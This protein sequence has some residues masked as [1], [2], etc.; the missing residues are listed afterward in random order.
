MYFFDIFFPF[1]GAFRGL[2]SVHLQGKKCEVPLFS[3][4]PFFP[5]IFFAFFSGDFNILNT[6]FLS[7]SFG[8]SLTFTCI[9]RIQRLLHFLLYSLLSF[10]FFLQCSL[11]IFW[12]AF[13]WFHCCCLWKNSLFLFI[14]SS[15]FISSLSSFSLFRGLCTTLLNK[16]HIVIT[17]TKHLTFHTIPMI[18]GYNKLQFKHCIIIC[19]KQNSIMFHRFQENYLDTTLPLKND[20][21]RLL[22]VTQK[23]WSSCYSHITAIV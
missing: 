13:S 22:E 5:S 17:T 16:I 20:I 21:P 14:I 3:L 9:H 7:I 11:P 12:F 8:G 4:L 18:G 2:T 6:Y 19:S 23:S 15:F 10:S 1:W